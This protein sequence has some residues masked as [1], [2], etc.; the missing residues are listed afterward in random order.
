[1]FEPKYSVTVQE[2][3]DT[4]E[5]QTRNWNI[6]GYRTPYRFIGLT[7]SGKMVRFQ[8]LWV[9]SNYSKKNDTITIRKT[10]VATSKAVV[11][12]M[13]KYG[14]IYSNGYYNL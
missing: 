4:P 11:W 5:L 6:E 1:M 14:H 9:S 7:P 13:D 3:V 2:I 10:H 12:E 8:R